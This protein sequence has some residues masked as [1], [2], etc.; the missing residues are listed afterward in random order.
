MIEKRQKKVL[1]VITKSNFGGAQKYVYELSKQLTERNFD[2]VVAFGGNGLLKEK[3]NAEKIKNISISDLD[4]DINFFKDIRTFFD[5][6][7]IIKKE[8]PD[9]IH[10]NS[11]KIGAIGSLAARIC[12]VPKI[13]FTF[14]G[15]AFNE[16]RNFLAKIIIKKIYWLTILWS[17]KTIAVS[18]NTKNQL[19]AIPF[20]KFFKK[21]IEVV[22]NDIEKIDFLDRN[23]AR[24]FISEKISANLSNKKIIGTIA[25]LH[26][27]KDL[28]FLIDSAEKI[29]AENPE[30]IFVIF[31]DGQEKEKLIK[32]ILD[33][34]INKNFFLLG[35]I[36]NAPKYLLGLDLFV[37]TSLSEGLSLAILEAK[38]AG[39]PIV[40][41]NIGGIPEAL[42]NY[43]LGQLFEKKDSDNFIKKIKIGL[44]QKPMRP[45][46]AVV[47]SMSNKT[48]DIYLK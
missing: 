25:E 35:F 17:H 33:K 15:L 18:E 23:S 6:I 21:K 41:T 12:R 37:L 39:I 2:V 3:L 1:Q 48:I 24:E 22:L 8:K 36:D 5:L 29:I 42:G 34:K 40:S 30:T 47:N 13:V 20:F 32:Q 38:Q 11:S 43:E 45:N 16:N 10:L 31:G 19:I 7:K 28:G 44:Q 26:P 4:R 27:I 14:H 46:N 9:I